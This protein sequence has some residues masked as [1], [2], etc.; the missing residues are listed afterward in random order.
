MYALRD[1]QDQGDYIQSLYIKSDWKFEPASDDI[2]EALTKFKQT[3]T[4]KQEENI[5]RRR[6]KLRHNLTPGKWDLIQELPKNDKFIIV[7]GDKNLGPCI[8][9]RD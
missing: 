3:I 7:D 6:Y 4:N 5:K 2:E 1:A 9:E 8:L